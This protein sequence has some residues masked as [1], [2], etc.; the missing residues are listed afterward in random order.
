VTASTTS[1]RTGTA[2]AASDEG[3]RAIRVLTT[4]KRLLLLTLFVGGIALGIAGYR[5]VNPPIEYGTLPPLQEAAEPTPADELTDLVLNGTE[6]SLAGRYSAEL[7]DGL[8]TALTVGPGQQGSP[9]MEVVDIRYLGSV[10]EGSDT[11][12]LYIAFGKIDGGTD[13]SAAF[14]LRVRDGEVIGVN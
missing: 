6:A 2:T 10:V 9:L 3:E 1:S 8:A 11:L 13:A 12:A 5:L 14:S 7:L 4:L